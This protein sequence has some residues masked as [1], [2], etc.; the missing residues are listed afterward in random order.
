MDRRKLR[1]VI[2]TIKVTTLMT[3]ALLAASLNRIVEVDELRNRSSEIKFSHAMKV[4][5]LLSCHHHWIPDTGE[6]RSLINSLNLS[7]VAKAFVLWTTPNGRLMRITHDAN[8]EDMWFLQAANSLPWYSRDD[9]ANKQDATLIAYLVRQAYLIH[10]L[11]DPVEGLIVRNF[12][13]FHD[14]VKEVDVPVKNIAEEYENVV[15]LALDDVWVLLYSVY[16]YYFLLARQDPGK[17]VISSTFFSDTQRDEHFNHAMADLLALTGRNQEEFR[18][19]YD[20]I[21]KY[22]DASGRKGGWVTEFNVLRDYPFVRLDD[23]RYCS[24]LPQFVIRRAFPGFYYDLLEDFAQ[25]EREK[26]N[27]QPYRNDIRSTFQ[28]LFQRYVGLQLEQLP[29]SADYL[30]PEFSYG[31]KGQKAD[32]PDWILA[33]P[34]KLP[35]FVEC[36]ARQPALAWQSESTPEHIDQDIRQTVTYA[37]A[38]ITKFL[39]R[40]DAKVAGTERYQGINRIIYALVM[41]DPFPFHALPNLAE[42]IEEI[43]SADIVGWTDLRHRVLFVPMSIRELETAVGLEISQGICIEDQLFEYFE[44]REGVQT[45]F[46]VEDGTIRFP[47]HLEEY[48]QEKYHNSCRIENPLIQAGWN[49]F[50]DFVSQ[51]MYGESYSDIEKQVRIKWIEENAYFRWVAEGRCHGHDVRHWQEAVE[52]YGRLEQEG[53][54]PL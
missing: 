7:F 12:I 19:I 5:T 27:K 14:L 36:K 20:T 45:R 33:R 23:D 39:Q 2:P 32:S 15:G 40:V 18:R 26:G 24:P 51:H 52:E 10:I 21:P 54:Q 34:G 22:H 43:A 44:Y 49:R 38:Q 37:L 42:R 3:D 8:T 31:T 50:S 17:W 29:G 46:V 47:R 13:M 11:N 9:V 6:A 48:L 1:S 25:R 4:I 53:N 35:V 28:L 41:H 30:S 16:A